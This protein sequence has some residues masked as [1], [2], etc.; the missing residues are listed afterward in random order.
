MDIAAIASDLTWR[1]IELAV[2]GHDEWLDAQVAAGKPEHTASST[3]GMYQ[4]A[5]E[6]F[7]TG[8]DPLLRTLLGHE[9]RTVRD[10]LAQATA[11]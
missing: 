3:L 11:S 8:T 5:H 1:T 2:L 10:L 4:A 9:Q 6:G 7:F